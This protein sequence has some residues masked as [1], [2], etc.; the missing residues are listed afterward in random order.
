MG[1]VLVLVLGA[2]PEARTVVRLAL[3]APAVLD[4]RAA[5]RFGGEGRCQYRLT[6]RQLQA[7]RVP[8][9]WQRGAD[10]GGRPQL[11]TRRLA[12]EGALPAGLR[13]G[14]AQLQ[15]AEAKPSSR[16]APR[17]LPAT[18][19][20]LV[21]AKVG[22]RLHHLEGGRGEE[23][24]RGRRRASRTGRSAS[25]RE[26]CALAADISACPQGGAARLPVAPSLLRHKALHSARRRLAG[27]PCRKGRCA[28][29]ARSKACWGRRSA[30]AV[31]PIQQ[32][33][34]V[35]PAGCAHLDVPHLDVP[36]PGGRGVGRGG[37]G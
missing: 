1:V 37:A 29:C 14:V 26:Q 15:H 11:G 22:G 24:R 10:R 31:S 5:G 12:S 18:P 21:P 25:H 19:T 27:G 4:L 35:A 16:Q 36:W 7:W 33:P 3:A 30:A 28:S 17:P 9:L 6:G 8:A 2:Q 13:R 32:F 23:V 20:H 34:A